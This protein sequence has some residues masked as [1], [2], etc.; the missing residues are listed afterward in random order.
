MDH[1]SLHELVALLAVGGIAVILLQVFLSKAQKTIAQKDATI[2]TLRRQCRRLRLRQKFQTPR[3]TNLQDAVRGQPGRQ[4]SNNQ[5]LDTATLE[6]CKQRIATLED[7]LVECNS[8]LEA[9][10]RLNEGGPPGL[11]D[12]SPVSSAVDYLAPE[13]NHLPLGGGQKLCAPSMDH[14][15][16]F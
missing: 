13:G 10:H 14:S 4:V 8:Q 11:E 16:T 6:D 5:A 7:K 1:G 2:D 9:L 12:N 3:G 15:V